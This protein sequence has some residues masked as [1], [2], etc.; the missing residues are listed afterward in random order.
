MKLKFWERRKKAHTFD[1]GERERRRSLII[2]RLL[3]LLLLLISMELDW[4]FESW[5]SSPETNKNFEALL[6]NLRASSSKKSE[7]KKQQRKLRE[8]DEYYARLE[9]KRKWRVLGERE[10]LLEG[11]MEKGED[12]DGRVAEEDVA[13]V[14]MNGTQHRERNRK[15]NKTTS[16]SDSE[17]FFAQLRPHKI[18]PKTANYVI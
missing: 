8:R 12:E 2:G 13:K 15:R 6:G 4:E 7:T 9:A 10:S 14:S 1:S 3:S 17:S 11:K 18:S 5:S 16:P